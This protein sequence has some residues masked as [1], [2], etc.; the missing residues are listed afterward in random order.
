MTATDVF[1]LLAEMGADLMMETLRQLDAGTIVPQIQDETKATLA[2]ILTRED[3]TMDFSKPAMTLYN[4]W[5]G[6]QPWPGA[7]TMLAGKKLAV[8]RMLP[9]EVRGARTRPPGE[10][11]VDQGTMFAACGEGT[12]LELVEVQPEGKRRMKAGEFLRGH[13]VESGARLG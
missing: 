4:R 9:T 2:P 10:L 7:W 11:L 13:A 6:F 5:R 12:W 8:H 3:G 1:P